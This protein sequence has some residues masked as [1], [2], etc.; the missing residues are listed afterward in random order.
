M[1]SALRAKGTEHTWPLCLYL[2]FDM[3]RRIFSLVMLLFF[4]GCKAS[5][6]LP[7][8]AGAD[9]PAQPVIV[10]RNH[11]H[12][13]LRLPKRDAGGAAGIT[14]S[15]NRLR[16]PR[17]HLLPAHLRPAYAAVSK[18][19]ATAAQGRTSFCSVLRAAKTALLAKLLANAHW[20]LLL[21]A[22]TQRLQL[23]V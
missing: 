20:R 13:K 15:D 21:I 6:C 14:A 4:V 19:I 18:D 9:P 23:L 10:K 7:P 1:S 22:L 11:R 12:V 2:I 8:A 16:V 3:N 17:Q 5:L